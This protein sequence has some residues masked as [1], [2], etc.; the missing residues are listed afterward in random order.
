M[1]VYTERRVCY[2]H[3]VMARFVQAISREE[4]EQTR[5][6]FQEYAASLGF[7]LCFQG[8][9]KELRE[10]PGDYGPPDGR[11]LLAFADDEL[12]GCVALRKISEGRCEMK[13]LYVR[14]QFRGKGL[15]RELAAGVI[16]EARNIGY[17]AMRL[18]TLPSMKEAIALYDSMGFQHIAPYRYNPI[19]GAIYMEL[20]LQ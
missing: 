3:R 10:L 2:E 4:L 13:R 12:A 20:Q 7:D 16:E 15:G 17:R 6:L 18:D 14:P 5:E 11:L 19:E 8:F 9:D 1:A